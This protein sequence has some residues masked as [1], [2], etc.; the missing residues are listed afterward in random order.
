MFVELPQ[1]NTNYTNY[2]THSACYYAQ[3]P[4]MLYMCK[5][6]CILQIVYP[7]LSLY[8]SPN[9]HLN[10]PNEVVVYIVSLSKSQLEFMVES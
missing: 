1:S 8:A 9:S 2:L 3:M 6:Y 10:C 7:E 4:F 5:E